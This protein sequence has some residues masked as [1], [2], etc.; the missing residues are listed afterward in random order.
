M[1]KTLLSLFALCLYVMAQAIQVAPTTITV[2]STAGGLATAI[3][4]AGGDL[5]T[6][7]NLTVTGNIDARDFKAMRDDMPA[8]TDIDLSAASVAAYTGAVGLYYLDSIY[9]SNEI[10]RSAF[11]SSWKIKSLIIP[12]TVTAIGVYAFAYSSLNTVSIPN[13][14]E[15]IEGA[16]FEN[17]HLLTSI[18]IP[19]SVTYIGD[20]AFSGCSNLHA[21]TMSS[22]V[23][24]TGGTV[25]ADCKK[26]TSIIIPNSLNRISGL[27]FGRCSGL[28]SITIPE[29]I[30]RIDH[31][32]F[33]EC[34]GLS[35][36]YSLSS[37]PVDI[38]K[39]PGVFYG[40]DTT[41]CI[42][43]VPKGSKALYQAAPQWKAFQN[44]VEMDDNTAAAND[45]SLA[46]VQA[47]VKQ[48]KLELSGLEAKADVVIYNMQGIELASAEGKEGALSIDL[49]A[50]G[51]Y[52]VRVGKQSI[53]VLY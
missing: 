15:Y 17:C 28:T 53:K 19:N 2:V 24:T 12:S 11:R 36:I 37:I 22:S 47:V 16:A 18:D 42:L 5:A 14:V 9:Y 33:Q 50:R 52:V 27:M 1:K 48:G 41:T 25:F 4:T 8:L 39:S 51:V 35:S 45:A 32:A 30:T 43:Y 49:P 38:D 44:I 10:P 46:N 20:L 34:S 21:V 13:S 23:N 7:T 3:T 29:S 40:V 26:L 6:V 31:W